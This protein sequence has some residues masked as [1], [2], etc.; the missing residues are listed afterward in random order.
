MSKWFKV[1]RLVSGTNYCVHNEVT[2]YRN[3]PVSP[4]SGTPNNE[5]GVYKEVTEQILELFQSCFI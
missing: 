3:I 5:A 4:I 1:C 2:L